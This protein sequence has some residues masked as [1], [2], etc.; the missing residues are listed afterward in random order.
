M[1]GEIGLLLF[2]IATWL[3][4]AFGVGYLIWLWFFVGVTGPFLVLAVPFSIFILLGGY[5]AIRFGIEEAD[6]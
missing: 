5:G 3:G 1:S 4:A 6:D 2:R